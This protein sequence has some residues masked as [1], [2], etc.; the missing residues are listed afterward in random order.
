MQKKLHILHKIK[1]SD[2][3]PKTLALSS[4]T[5]YNSVKSDIKDKVQNYSV[6]KTYNLL[7]LARLDVDL[8]VLSLFA[9]MFD[10]RNCPH[11]QL[12]VELHGQGNEVLAVLTE[13]FHSFVN[14]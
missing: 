3:T 4:T 8:H 12:G 9:S 5:E 1:L 14:G 2:A 10:M 7:T 11:A 6:T 13:L